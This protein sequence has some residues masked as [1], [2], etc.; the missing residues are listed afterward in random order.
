MFK[1]EIKYHKE[2]K[3]Q[4]GGSDTKKVMLPIYG[5]DERDE[6]LL[7][8]VKEFNMMV[9]DG[10][11]SKDDEIGRESTQGTFT[12][13]KLKNKLKAIKEM[14]RK[15]RACLKGEENW[16]KLVEGQPV[17][18]DINCEVDNTNEID[19]FLIIKLIWWPKL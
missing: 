4:L 15:F 17:V 6:T 16:L 5:D 10:N 2:F 14:Y 8:L 7:I 3:V 19:I 18:A 1:K 12:D 11:L 9:E 13:Q